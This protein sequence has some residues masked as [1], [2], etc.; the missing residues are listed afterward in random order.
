MKNQ[1]YHYIIQLEGNIYWAGYNTFT[2]Q[3]RKARTYNSSK[4]AL[5]EG[6]AAIKR[7][8]L[9]TRFRIL[10]VE[11]NILEEGDWRDIE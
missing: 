10:T 6:S 3:I 1:N 11:V 9:D 2:D 8:K 7:N 5:T 4:I